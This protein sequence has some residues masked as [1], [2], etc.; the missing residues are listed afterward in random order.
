MIKSNTNN[1]IIPE[2][3]PGTQLE[4]KSELVKVSPELIKQQ[5]S[6]IIEL[7]LALKNGT[8]LT[9]PVSKDGYVNCTKLCQ[10]GNKRIGNWIANKQSNEL[11]EAYSKLPGITLERAITGIPV[12]ALSRVIPGSFE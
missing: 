9:I 8:Y 3:N 4:F 11:L 10:A 1:K 5:F 7:K 2:L 12:I 6:D